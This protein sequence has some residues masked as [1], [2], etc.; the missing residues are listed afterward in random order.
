[1]EGATQAPTADDREFEGEA[2]TALPVEGATQAPTIAKRLRV[3]S[4]DDDEKNRFL[5]LAMGECWHSL[6]LGCPVYTCKGGGFICGLCRDFVV[7]NNDFVTGEDFPKLW[8]WVNSLPALNESLGEADAASFIN[9]ID[10][11][12]FVNKVYELLKKMNSDGG[13]R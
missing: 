11:R 3:Y 12:A 5:T 10:R 9:D 7:A 4:D 2:P 1:V 8:K 13:E 6:E